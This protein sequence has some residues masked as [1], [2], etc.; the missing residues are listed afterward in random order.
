MNKQNKI[1]WILLILM[2]L[3]MAWNTIDL[4]HMFNGWH[5]AFRIFLNV[6]IV[7]L[8]IASLVVSKK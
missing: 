4:A 3:V 6:V 8:F 2:A 7:A 1:I 5:L